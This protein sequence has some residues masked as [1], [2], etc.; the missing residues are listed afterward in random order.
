MPILP[1][2]G[3]QPFAMF[4]D[5]EWWWFVRDEV[6]EL[7]AELL[8]AEVCR[9]REQRDFFRI[10]QVVAPQPDHVAAGNRVSGRAD[11]DHPDLGS[12]RLSID[13]FGEWNGNEMTALHGNHRRGAAG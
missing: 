3:G 5:G 11:V 12:S 8:L 2:R 7:L 6:F 9:L 10:L 1:L 13:H 4:V